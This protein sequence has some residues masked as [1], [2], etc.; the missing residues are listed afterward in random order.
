[1]A[2]HRRLTFAL[3][4]LLPFFLGGCSSEHARLQA[5][6]AHLQTRNAA[7][8]KQVQQLTI[9]KKEFRGMY[10]RY[11]LDASAYQG[12]E[13]FDGFLSSFCPPSAI[14]N[15]AKAV[16][17]GFVGT[18]WPYWVALIGKIA[19]FSVLVALSFLAIVFF[20]SEIDRAQMEKGQREARAH[21]QC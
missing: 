9:E 15:G 10:D 20:L 7:L 13:S 5:E 8:Q 11:Q 1:M 14:S 12:C 2:T 4:L 3:F 17:F 18:G 16:S 21:R 19:A 6:V